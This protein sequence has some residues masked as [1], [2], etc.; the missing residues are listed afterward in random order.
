MSRRLIYFDHVSATPVLPEV[1]EAMLPFFRERFGNP[2]SLHRH[3]LQ[4]RDALKQAREQVAALIH[5]PS[6]DDI[7]F[8]SGGTEAANLAIKGVARA[9]QR[10]GR[11]IVTTT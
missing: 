5:A 8:T 11:H 1:V 3:G 4:A 6:P 10:H 9:S 2:S 7:L